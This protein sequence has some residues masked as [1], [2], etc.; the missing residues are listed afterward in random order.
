MKALNLNSQTM[1]S[2]RHDYDLISPKYDEPIFDVFSASECL[3]LTV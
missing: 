3:R 1:L 2:L